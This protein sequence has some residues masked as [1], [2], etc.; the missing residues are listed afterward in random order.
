MSRLRDIDWT[1][2]QALTVDGFTVGEIKFFLIDSVVIARCACCECE[3]EVEP[4][5]A[6]YPCEG[7]GQFDSVTSPLVKLGL[8]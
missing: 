6:R 4:D 7:R 8:I 3:H 2:D 5:A 1:D